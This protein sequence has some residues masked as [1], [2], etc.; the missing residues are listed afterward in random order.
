[1][2]IR[3]RV[4]GVDYTLNQLDQMRQQGTPLTMQ[5]GDTISFNVLFLSLIHI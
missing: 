3:D 5:V 2:C 1:M 4:N